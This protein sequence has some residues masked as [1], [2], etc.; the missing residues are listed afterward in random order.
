[1]TS[2]GPGAVLLTASGAEYEKANSKFNDEMDK[3]YKA[4]AEYENA[5]RESKR[6]LKER[7]QRLENLEKLGI[8]SAYDLFPKKSQQD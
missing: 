8:E 3:N 4:L 6:E 1:M 2:K 5:L 7:E